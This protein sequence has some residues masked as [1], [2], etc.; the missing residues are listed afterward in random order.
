MKKYDCLPVRKHKKLMK[1]EMEF[2]VVLAGA[3]KQTHPGIL[4]V[5]VIICTFL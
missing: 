1:E 4:L 5:K 2:V 3:K